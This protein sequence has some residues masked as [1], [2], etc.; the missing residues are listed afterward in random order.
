MH[1]SSGQDTPLLEVKN[2]TKRFGGLI[3]V[4]RVNME[5]YPAEVVGLVGDNGAGKS[6]LIKMISGVYTPDEGQMFFNHQPM[7][8]SSPREA[9]NM[10]IETI[11]QDLAL[12]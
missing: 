9:R 8:I 1:E 11:Y 5:V 12:A 6:T 7:Q 2:L 3:A 10:G 4:N